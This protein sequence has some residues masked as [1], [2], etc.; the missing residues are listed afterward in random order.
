[1][2]LALGPRD[3]WSVY[4]VVF[5]ILE[6]I[7]YGLIVY[8][9]RW[10]SPTSLGRGLIE[11]LLWQSS[12]RPAPAHPPKP[13]FALRRT[14]QTGLPFVFEDW[15]GCDVPAEALCRSLHVR[16]AEFCAPG[17]CVPALFFSLRIPVR[18]RPCASFLHSIQADRWQCH[19]H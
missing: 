5:R 4:S 10:C 6:Y 12:Q 9:W 13:V 2:F 19:T 1:L 17:T 8:F 18:L 16:L 3:T 14:A 11:R 7:P 15:F